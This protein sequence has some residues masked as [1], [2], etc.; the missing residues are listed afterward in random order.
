[1]GDSRSS[2]ADGT[3]ELGVRT[4]KA[5]ELGG[6]VGLVVGVLATAA[7][8]VLVVQNTRTAPIR[9]LMFDAEPALW[10]ILVATFVGG[11]LSGV[12]ALGLLTSR[13]TR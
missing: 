11:L 6:V 2:D 13:P 4:R 3:P 9:W 7:V 12:L 1:M 5:A 8:A 10:L